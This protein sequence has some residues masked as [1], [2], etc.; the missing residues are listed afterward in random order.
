M[1]VKR[2]GVITAILN[3][4]EKSNGLNNID[5]NVVETMDRILSDIDFSY[6]N[7]NL[8]TPYISDNS[9]IAQ[10]LQNDLDEYFDFW[11]DNLPALINPKI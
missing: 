3:K 9:A 11:D 7:V 10:F 1:F 8:P 6:K 5:E 2:V 4:L